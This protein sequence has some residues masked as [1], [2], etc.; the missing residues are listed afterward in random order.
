MTLM[1]LF[2]FYNAQLSIQ[3]FEIV[4]SIICEIFNAT[5]CNQQTNSINS[6]VPQEDNGKEN[7]EIHG[8]E[9]H[10][11]YGC[12]ERRVNKLLCESNAVDFM[13]D[14]ND[15]ELKNIY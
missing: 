8:L 2:T 13:G 5:I 3:S 10:W 4:K 9:S 14:Y 1:C 7:K 6:E 15:K 12:K 11:F